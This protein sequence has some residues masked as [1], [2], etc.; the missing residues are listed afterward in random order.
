MSDKVSNCVIS[1]STVTIT[2]AQTTTVN[3]HVQITAMDAWA[4]TTGSVTGT[5]SNFGVSVQT[6]DSTATN[7]YALAVVGT[8]AALSNAPLATMTVVVA[9]TLVNIMDVGMVEFTVT[10]KLYPF[11]KDSLAYISFPSYYNPFIGCMMRCSMYDATA[12]KDGERLY[13]NVAWDY[14]L[15]VM[16]PATDA[17]IDVAFVLRVYGV[18]MN[19]HTT[20]GNFGFGLT[21]STY[22]VQNKLNE[23]KAAADTTTGGWTAKLPIDITSMALSKSNLRSTTDITAKFT[24][25]TTTDGI[26]GG[27]DF[28]AMTLPYQWGGVHA[29]ADG[30]G[31]ASAS[32]KL[33][34]TTG[35]GTAAT[36]STTKVAG[37]IV[38]VSGCTVVFELDTAATKLAETG[39]YEFVLS[40]V[41]TTEKASG[42]AAMNLGSII[43]S[44]GKVADGGRGWSS[45]QLFP[46]L[47]ALTAPTGKALLEFSSDMATVSAGTYTK[48]AVC[49]KPALGNFAADVSVSVKGSV[50]KTNPA[51]L[52]VKMGSA[53]GC[54]DMGTAATTQLSVHNVRW[55]VDNGTAAYTNLPTQM[56]TV[57]GNKAT[58]NVADAI[59]C[60]LSGSSVPIIVTVS[61]VPFADVK[62]SLIKSIA[63]DTDKTDNSVGITP[64]QGEVVTLK[65]GAETG[66][67]GFKCGATVTGTEL[68]YK[69]EGTDV[70]QF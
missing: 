31:T 22:W 11:G 66:V 60:S 53:Q 65:V 4:A 12:K 50:F 17:A 18:Q 63:D 10:P 43:L 14:T 33:V 19:A 34:T 6:E 48:D 2:M 69:I 52:S 30:T 21:N 67:L 35:T 25:P 26:T 51:K 47:P 39:S 37:A 59:T 56:V 57:N 49:I 7:Q 28:I 41:P 23:F 40:S 42:G 38:Q 64:N 62:V 32:L 70:A 9:R 20:A 61:A 27:S 5:V 16:G 15:R 55:S 46:A 13:C 24:L 36:T 29:W 54:A 44:V 3:F 45:A 58:V 8:T 68:K 1:G